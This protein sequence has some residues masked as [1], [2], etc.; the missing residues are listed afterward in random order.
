M[1][2]STKNKPV[3]AAAP[4]TPDVNL[5]HTPGAIQTENWTLYR[6]NYFYFVPGCGKLEIKKFLKNGKEVSSSLFNIEGVNSDG[7]RIL[8]EVGGDRQAKLF[9]ALFKSAASKDHGLFRINSVDCV[10][11]T[12]SSTFILIP[13]DPN[14]YQKRYKTIFKLKTRTKPASFNAQGASM[15]NC[16]FP[17]VVKWRDEVFTYPDGS[18]VPAP[19]EWGRSIG[20]DESMIDFDSLLAEEDMEPIAK[21]NRTE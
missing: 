11:A 5:A 7:A 12:D 16:S 14:D 2:K 17:K 10:P 21:R 6:D 13:E 3:A 1:S 9:D 4:D 20:L 18:Y 8:I 19:N 15:Q